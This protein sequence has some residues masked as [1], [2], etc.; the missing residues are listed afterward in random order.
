M[1]SAQIKIENN[2]LHRFL[3]VKIHSKLALQ[4]KM[5]DR[6][7]RILGRGKIS[8]QLPRTVWVSAAILRLKSKKFQLH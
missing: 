7:M 8:Y 5:F 3:T 1:T 6:K 2:L 4:S